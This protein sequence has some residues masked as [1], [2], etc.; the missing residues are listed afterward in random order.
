MIGKVGQVN[1]G[2]KLG[3][4]IYNLCLQDDIKNIV[5]IG[6]WNG[7]GTTKCIYD[8]ISEKKGEYLV[9]SLEC[10]TEFHNIAL[11]NYKNLPK[12]NNFN[13]ILGTIITPEENK[14][15][16]NN[17]ED[18]FF[19][20]YSREVQNYWYL[21]DL[22][23]CKKVPNVLSIIPDSIDLLILD[24]GEFSSFAEYQKLKNRTRYF[25]LDD[26]NT[27][28]NNEIAILM[29][30]DSNYQI[31]HDS[32]DRNG[33]LVS[34]KLNNMIDIDDIITTDGYLSFC[35]DNDISYVNTGYFYNILEWRGKIQKTPNFD[36][37]LIGHS[38]YPVTD[39]I[40]SKFNKLFCV[41]RD[42]DNKNTF[43]IPLGIT[44]YCDD[45]NLHK[46][47]GDKKIM[48]DVINRDITKN[49]LAYINFNISTF[50][51]ERKF[52][53]DKFSNE[54]WVKVGNIDNSINGRKKFLVDIK[55]SKFVFCP[56]GNGIDTHRLWET[57]YMG[58]IPIVKYE[59]AH[60]LFKDLPI[61]FIDD[62]NDI[63]EEY[64]NQ[65]YIQMTSKDWNIDKLKI[66][67]W[68]KFIKSINNERN[69]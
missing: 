47:Y 48:I 49:N 58:S 2:S 33:F 24:G 69:L 66:S 57:L 7:M 68:L 35:Q 38:D 56:R 12:L 62:W 39:K 31:I 34:K 64:L 16:K 15:P 41:N 19:N 53:F 44:N 30:K 5:E 11:I 21:Q 25:I 61:L 3:E 55:S 67:Y 17:Y 50:P 9:Y 26:V 14:D 59:R 10:N 29:R 54:N 18:I 51:S 43:G 40:S 37:C 45:S 20:Q 4:I 65:I 52:I 32:D 46:I 13:M 8:A 63:N 60:H 1:R 42:T 23:N 27:I 6:T 36:F 22:E 28:K